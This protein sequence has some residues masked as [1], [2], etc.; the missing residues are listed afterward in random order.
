MPY[1]IGKGLL[2]VNYGAVSQ[3]Q[4]LLYAGAFQSAADITTT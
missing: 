4:V 3:H 1:K 2:V